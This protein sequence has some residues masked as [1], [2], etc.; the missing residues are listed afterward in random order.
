MIHTSFHPKLNWNDLALMGDTDVAQSDRVDGSS[1]GGY[2]LTLALYKQFFEGHMIDMS[3]SGWS[4]TKQ[5]RVPRSSL[6][7]EIQQA[8][9]TDDEV[10]AARLLWSEI[11]G[12]Q[13]TKQN[14]T[15]AAKETPGIIVF[16]AKGAHD[17]LKKKVSRLAGTR[18]Q[19]RTFRCFLLKC[20][21]TPFFVRFEPRSEP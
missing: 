2:V 12:Y 18:R 15:D 13:V 20:V 21:L 1:T 10:F 4:T 14:V 17:A 6:S 16:D 7:A 9:N 5:E 3:L 19:C 8:C 11:N